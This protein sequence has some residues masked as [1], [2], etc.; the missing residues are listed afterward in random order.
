M[1]VFAHLIKGLILVNK[2]LETYEIIQAST[3]CPRL[4]DIHSKFDC[5]DSEHARLHMCAERYGSY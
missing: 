3:A 1:K 4:I 2:S 5:A